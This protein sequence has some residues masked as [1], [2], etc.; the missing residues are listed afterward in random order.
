MHIFKRLLVFK[1]VRILF[2][3]NNI[4]AP[5]NCERCW[6]SKYDV[7]GKSILLYPLISKTYI[8]Y[9]LRLHRF[10][11]FWC[12]HNIE[13]SRYRLSFNLT[14]T[15]CTTRWYVDQHITKSKSIN[16][17]FIFSKDWIE[18]PFVPNVLFIQ[19]FLKVII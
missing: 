12:S 9:F 13:S 3:F 1:W 18:K 7:G 4:N 2:L 17:P 6:G 16:P 11:Q 10:S 8:W 19:S 15:Y 14:C 5:L